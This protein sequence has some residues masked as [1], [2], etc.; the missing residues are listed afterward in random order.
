LIESLTSVN[1]S[2]LPLVTFSLA[3]LDKA[4]N[5]TSCIMVHDSTVSPSKNQG[6]AQLA[7]KAK[8]KLPFAIWEEKE[9]S[10][11]L[12]SRIQWRTGSKKLRQSKFILNPR[13]KARSEVL[14]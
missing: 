13:L 12:V 10:G 3:I 2:S 5:A 14:T 8:G 11:C 9:N 1:I 7:R 6:A 4:A